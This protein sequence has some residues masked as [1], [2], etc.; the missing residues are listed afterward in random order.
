MV[1]SLLQVS[2]FSRPTVDNILFI[3]NLHKKNE[4]ICST[5]ISGEEDN[6][7]QEKLLKTIKI[8]RD[9][10]EINK[11]LPKSNYI[12]RNAGDK[13]NIQLC[14]YSAQNVMKW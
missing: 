13:N 12:K 1:A 5:F 6:F 9:I 7:N 10:G 11:F 3:I 14:K 8:P 2:P 4:K